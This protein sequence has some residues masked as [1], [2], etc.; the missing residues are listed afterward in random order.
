MGGGI[1]VRNDTKFPILVIASQLTPLYWGRVD[2]G[3]T[4]NPSNEK[5]LGKVWFTIR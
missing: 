3:G 5:N 1:S 2:P 4:W